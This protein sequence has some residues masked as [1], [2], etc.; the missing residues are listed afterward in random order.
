[1]RL[2]KRALLA[3]IG[4]LG[5]AAVVAS[6]LLGAAAEPATASSH[7]EAPLISQDPMADNTDLYA[8]RSPDQPDT[9][10][11]IANYIPLEEP[12]GG[13]NFVGF[14]DDVL[15][16]IHIDNDGDA[17]ADVN[18]EFRFKTTNSAPDSFLYAGPQVSSPTDPAYFRQQKYTVTRTSRRLWEDKGIDTVKPR[19]VLGSGNVPPV[20]VGPRTTPNYDNIAAQ[21]ITT[22]GDGVK[23]FAGPRDD[24]FFVDLGAIFDLGGLRPFNQLHAIPLPT[25]KGIDGVSG[26]NTHTI[27]M[28]IPISQLTK[29]GK[30]FDTT[31]QPVLGIYASASR[32]RIRVL[33]NDG[34]SFGTGGWTQVSRLGNPLIN[35][36]IIP[37]GQKD[38]WNAQQPHRDSQF[39]KY[40]LKPELAGIIN[41]L[42]GSAL[43][44]VDKE[45]RT[46]L[47]LILLQGVPG[48]NQAVT[49]PVKADL[50]RLNVAIAP[51]APVGQG[52][53]LTVITSGSDAPD[54]AGFPNG[55][56]L[57]DDVTDIE[58][59]A[60]A[61]GYGVAL[62]SLFGLP[63]KSP[64]NLVG[65]GVDVNDKPFLT[66][67]P[68]QAAPHSGYESTL[69]VGLRGSAGLR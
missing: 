38:Y 65:D 44:P 67:F 58:L 54:L 25:D 5:A 47:S 60:V 68:Y 28:Q 12:N 69:H 35:E 22:V 61:Q 45:N 56:R 23:V 41:Q 39:E 6:T 31:S 48:V 4:L 24:A 37:S 32:Q 7:R 30:T 20:N 3:P 17:K 19:Q 34:K 59:K 49:N 18:Y 42:Y 16:G 10:T 9:V 8:F 52:K 57:E 13:P 29:D 14:G 33:T 43:Q 66:S 27:T 40:Y 36:V 1:M 2:T 50:L 63:N 64:N 62:N 51:S 46:D 26:Y 53:P 21:A 11:I 55:R 15:Y